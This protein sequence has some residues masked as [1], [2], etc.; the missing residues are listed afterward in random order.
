MRKILAITVIAA[1]LTSGC[2]SAAGP[3]MAIAQQPAAVN[4]VSMADY[5]MR[6]PVGSRVRVEKVDGTS[7]RGTL[8]KATADAIVVQK[9][10]R[11]PETPIEVPL[12]QIA[13]VTV[14]GGG[15]AVA[16]NVAIGVATGVGVFL[17][18]MAILAATLGD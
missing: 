5:V 8:M 6:L 4:T 18:I 1:M 12:A 7:F 13:R 15:G 10:T 3:R 16:R 9:N 14:D 11:I 2:A 17:G